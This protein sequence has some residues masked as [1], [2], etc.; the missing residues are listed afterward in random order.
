M[1]DSDYPVHRILVVEDS[2]MV[3]KV[4]NHLIRNTLNVEAHFVE[5]FAECQSLVEEYESDF[6]AALADLNLPDAPNGE[7]AD[8]LLDRGIPCIVLTGSYSEDRR[9]QMLAMGL[10]DYI[11]KESRYSYDH[12]VRLLRRL[13]KNQHLKLMVVDDSST[14]RTYVRSLLE[15]H[16]YQVV[17]AENGVDALEKLQQHPDIRLIMTDYNMPVMDGFELVRTIRQDYEKKDLVIIGLSSEESASLSAKFIKNGANDFL[18]KPFVH[19]E[20]H[21]RVMQC[22]ESM[23]LLEQVRGMSSLD[24]LTGVLN[25]RALFVQGKELY[26]QEQQEGHGLAVALLDID[27]FKTVNEE[28][29]NDAGDVVLQAVSHVLTETLG[30]FDIYR[31]GDKQFGILMPRVSNHQACQIMHGVRGRV[32][33]EVIELPQEDIAVTVSIGVTNDMSGGFE[34]QIRAAEERLNQAIEAGRNFV[35]GDS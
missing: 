29:G 21:C 15:Q 12:A 22:I 6:F 25:R 27:Y 32:E 33:C 10:V 13:E 11:V 19:E 8:Y 2:P 5:T 20:F 34:K 24:A 17:E 35:I 26:Q 1:L 23:E 7:V 9:E 30:R 3:R 4:L 18:K 28:F 31:T 16:L 14:A